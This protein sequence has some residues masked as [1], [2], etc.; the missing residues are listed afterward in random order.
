[1]KLFIGEP[2]RPE[3]NSNLKKIVQNLVIE[4]GKIKG[5]VTDQG[6][7]GAEVVINAAGAWAAEVARMA[8]VGIPVTPDSHEAAVT[9]PVQRFFTR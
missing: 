2:G 7:Y 5:V 8:G 4:S 9:E 1:M 3:L 6:R